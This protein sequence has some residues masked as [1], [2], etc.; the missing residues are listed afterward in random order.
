MIHEGNPGHHLA[1]TVAKETEHLPNF[2]KHP[3]YERYTEAPSRFNMPTV[4]DEGWAMYAEQLGVELGLF[5]E[6]PLYLFGYYAVG[7]L[8]RAC[9]LVVDTGRIHSFHHLIAQF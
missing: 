4:F 3:M 6:D 5:D 1:S 8:V 9:R 7:S 2:I